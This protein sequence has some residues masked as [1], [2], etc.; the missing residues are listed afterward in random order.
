MLV[1]TA[2]RRRRNR[3]EDWIHSGLCRSLVSGVETHLMMVPKRLPDSMTEYS[4][5][6]GS[7]FHSITNP[8]SCVVDN[9]PENISDTSAERSPI[10]PASE[11]PRSCNAPCSGY[12]AR[13]QRPCD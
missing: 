12:T 4:V 2:H 5:I 11:E 3:E 10:Y 13:T 6:R 8:G 9:Y 7:H 1:E